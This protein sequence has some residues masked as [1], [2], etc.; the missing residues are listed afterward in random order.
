M[1]IN[2]SESNE[3]E[4]SRLTENEPVI[5]N[6]T[7]E[8]L[9]TNPNQPA[10]PYRIEVQKDWDLRKIIA[11]LTAVPMMF[12]VMV[13]LMIP[14]VFITGMPNITVS[15]MLTVVSEIIVLFWAL[16]ITGNLKNIKETLYLKNFKW[17]N[18]GLG[19]GVGTV[20]FIGL[21]SLSILF[22]KIGL[23]PVESSETSTMLG[24][25]GGFEQ[26]L[27]LLIVVP[28]IV[29]VIEELFFRGYVFGFLRNSKKFKSEKIA[30][31]TAIIVSSFIFAIMHAQGFET[32][33]DYF[34]VAWIFIVALTNAKLLE[35]TQSIYTPIASHV[36][37]NFI[38]AVLGFIAST[39]T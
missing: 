7:T 11:S 16:W 2:N 23:A 12:V 22:S 6:K 31:W 8:K 17:K 28:F 9:P 26:F 25:L 32:F 4:R 36:T 35:K 34:I 15:L 20:L 1:P 5:E 29:P 14:I 3:N 27:I 37:Y 38:T 30:F 24:E 19:V 18:I 33:N 10:N 39:A 13:A 21:Q